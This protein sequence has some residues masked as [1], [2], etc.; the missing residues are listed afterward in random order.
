MMN[1]RAK[2]E[3]IS[4]HFQWVFLHLGRQSC[5]RSVILGA[6]ARVLRADLAL[7]KVERPELAEHSEARLAFRVHDLRGTFVTL[8]LA[9]GKTETWV[10]DRTG[11][12][13]SV[14][15]NRYRRTARLASELGVGVL[16]PLDGAI[17][18]F[19]PER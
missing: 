8:S 4:R 9:N 6:L 13:S 19:R 14:M 16:K 5:S 2:G 17:P 15:I 10:A 18:E 3:N 11:H 12:K 1:R 7:A